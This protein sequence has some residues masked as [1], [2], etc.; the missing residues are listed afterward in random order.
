MLRI[1]T[2]DE[3]VKAICGVGCCYQLME[4]RFADESS[5]GKNYA[6]FHV[7]FILNSAKDLSLVKLKCWAADCETDKEEMFDFPLSSLLTER[8]MTIGRTALNMASLALSRMTSHEGELQ[9]ATFYPRALLQALLKER[10]GHIP[11]DLKRLRG[12]ARKV[13]SPCDYV[14]AALR[15]LNIP[16]CQVTEDEVAKFHQQH[17]HHQ[18]KMAAFFQLRAALAPLVETVVLLDRLLYLVEQDCVRD[19][20]LVRLFDPVT[21]PRCHAIVAFSQA[22]NRM[23]AHGQGRLLLLHQGSV[24]RKCIMD[25]R[26]RAMLTL[27]MSYEASHLGDLL[28]VVKN[29]T[30]HAGYRSILPTQADD[31]PKATMLKKES[32]NHTKYASL[33]FPGASQVDVYPAEHL[34]DYWKYYGVNGTL[35]DSSVMVLPD[36]NLHV[37]EY[38]VVD[39]GVDLAMY[40][41]DEK[42]LGDEYINFQ[43]TGKLRIFHVTALMPSK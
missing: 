28:K 35:E 33:S 37:F 16:G 14:I 40:K 38:T 15:K 41:A 4:E 22:Y 21:S 26:L 20:F 19:A 31:S 9:G 2:E 17:S 5:R 11:S 36:D 34:S 23:M 24:N 43:N 8:R 25:R 32:S 3:S 29:P 42:A 13:S 12:L 1:F 6:I 10:L 7:C 30:A 27:R 39:Q 18:H